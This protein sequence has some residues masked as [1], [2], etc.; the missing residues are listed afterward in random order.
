MAGSRRKSAP[1]GTPAQRLL[2][3]LGAHPWAQGL[4]AREVGRDLIVGRPEWL[5]PKGE[6]EDDD[7]LRLQAIGGGCYVVKARLSSGRYQDTGIAGELEAIA[8]RMGTSLRHYLT[9]WTKPPA[10]R[11]RRTSGGRY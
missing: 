11:R 7:R 10:K 2:D 1:S 4:Y 6:Q 5:G 3:L 9:V 8:A